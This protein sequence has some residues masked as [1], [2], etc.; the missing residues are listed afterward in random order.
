MEINFYYVK[1]EYIAFLK[2][3]EKDARGF[4]CVPNTQYRSR[5]KFLFGAC[6]QNNGINYFVPVSHQIKQGD[7]NIVIKTKPKKGKSIELGSLRFAYM[8]PV[9]NK[10]LIQLDIKNIPEYEQKR[11]INDELAF[12]RREIDKIKKQAVKSFDAITTSKNDKLLRNSCDFLVLQSAYITYCQENGIELPKVL[13]EQID[14]QANKSD[15]SHQEQSKSDQSEK[16]VSAD[17]NN[18]QQPKYI[19]R[20][21]MLGG[22]KIIKQ[23][24]QSPN[25]NN[26]KTNDIPKKKKKNT[27]L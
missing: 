9:P 20:G 15:E 26:D 1:D 11:R 7:N 22:A 17:K 24:Q 2:K 16:T 27:S 5:N 12:C 4:T 21:T 25:K 23:K 19:G 18:V 6:F 3:A 8:I 13:Q 10:C 14:S